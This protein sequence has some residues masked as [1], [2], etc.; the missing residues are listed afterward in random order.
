MKPSS[1]PRFLFYYCNSHWIRFA[2]T[3]LMCACLWFSVTLILDIRF[4]GPQPDSLIQWVCSGTGSRKLGPLTSLTDYSVMQS[5]VTTINLK[6]KVTKI[7][8][9][10]RPYLNSTNQSI[11]AIKHD[12][13]WKWYT[14]SGK[15]KKL[16]YSDDLS[17]DL[18]ITLTKDKQKN[19][20]TKC[21][22]CQYLISMC[23]EKQ[24]HVEFIYHFKKGW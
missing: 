14:S 23:K 6:T 20:Q 22:W 13:T 24:L 5:G 4:H 9:C 18:Q 3:T 16:L 21:T 17:W 8:Q 15:E 10:Y 7:N 19:M 11:K 2:F 1:I 12:K